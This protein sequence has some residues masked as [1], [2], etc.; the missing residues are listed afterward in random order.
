MKPLHATR[1]ILSVLIS[2]CVASA[3]SDDAP[4]PGPEA[5]PASVLATEL[6]GVPYPADNSPSP[7]KVELGRLLFWDPILSG[8]RDVACASCHDPAFGYSDGRALSIGT[9]GQP[10]ARGALT[11]LD[12]AWNGWTASTPRP[13]ASQAPMFW[14]NRARSL[15]EQARG[16]ISNEAEMRGAAFDERAIFPELVRRLTSIP[17]YVERFEAAFGSPTI[18]DRAIVRAIATF[19]RTL[20]TVP[21]YERWLAG[22][23][24]AISDAAKRGV[25]TFRRVGCS[26]C[27]SGPMLSDFTLHKLTRGGE[28]IRTPSLRNV[29]RTAPYMHDGRA[30]NFDAVFDVYRRVDERADPLFRDLRVPDRGDRDEVIA[31]LQSASDGDFDR[32]IPTRVPS[33]LPV[34]GRVAQR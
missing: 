16:P 12:A 21:S 26:R 29:I 17:E 6:G 11:V 1:S 8:D 19:E 31:F 25:E 32:T 2:A 30:A 10:A 7:A 28:A 18:D 5:A 20:V 15:E 34:G 22:D 9:G 13:D 3:C 14:D 24:S 27:H 23:E 33:A 4:E